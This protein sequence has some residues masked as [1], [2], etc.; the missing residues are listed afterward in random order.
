MHNVFARSELEQAKKDARELTVQEAV[1]KNAFE[2]IAKA[3]RDKVE[4]ENFDFSL[5]LVFMFIER[6]SGILQRGFFC[7]LLS[8]YL[9]TTYFYVFHY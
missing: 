1:A 9:E 3:G 6:G 4:N 2:K 7:A 8:C 5:K